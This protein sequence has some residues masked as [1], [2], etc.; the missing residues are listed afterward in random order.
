MATKRGAFILFEGIDRCGKTTQCTKLVEYLRSKNVNAELWRFPDRSTAIGQS[1]NAYLQ[2]KSDLN[3]QAIHL[4]FAANRWEKSDAMLQALNSGVSLIVD[5][6]CFSGIA[7]TVAKE[8]PGMDTEWCRAPERGLPAPDLVLY[9]SLSPEASAKRGGYGE[10]RYEKA[11]FQQKVSTC[12]ASLMDDRWISIEADQ[13]IEDIH[14]QV[15][16][17]AERTLGRVQG[18]GLPVGKLWEP[19][20]FRAAD[21]A[22]ATSCRS[23]DVVVDVQLGSQQAS[24]APP[25]VQ[26][27][28]PPTVQ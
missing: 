12:F 23:A 5:R 22:E 16:A 18:Q 1:I 27:S 24:K 4:L 7:Y 25:A 14:Q 2:N 3:D 9:M 13:P 8:L 11:E 20:Q 19:A 6:Y 17:A 28:D 10:E 21:R 26:E 15:V